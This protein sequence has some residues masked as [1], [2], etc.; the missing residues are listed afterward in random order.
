VRRVDPPVNEVELVAMFADPAPFVASFTEQARAA[1]TERAD[2][3][4]PA[5]GVLN[6]LLFAAG[7]REVDGVSVMDCVGVTLLYAE[8]LAK[9][10]ATTGLHAGRRWEYAKAPEEITSHLTAFRGTG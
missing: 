7:L 10:H 2:V 1:I 6:E 5:E 8:L 3:I 9:L 4:I